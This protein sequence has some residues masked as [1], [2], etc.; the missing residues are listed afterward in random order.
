MTGTDTYPYPRNGQ[1]G[2]CPD[3]DRPVHYVCGSNSFGHGA[4]YHDDRHDGNTC[5]PGKA[6]FEREHPSEQS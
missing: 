6:R 2:I 3:C 4:W 1:T 5:W